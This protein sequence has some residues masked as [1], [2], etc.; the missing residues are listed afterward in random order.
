MHLRPT[1]SNFCRWKEINLRQYSFDSG[2]W[3]K[4]ML[5]FNWKPHQTQ[6]RRKMYV[7][8]MYRTDFYNFIIINI[9]RYQKRNQIAFT[10]LTSTTSMVV[11]TF[12]PK[13][14]EE[15]RN[16]WNKKKTEE[17]KKEISSSHLRCCQTKLQRVLGALRIPPPPP[18]LTWGG[19]E[20]AAGGG[21]TT[22]LS[23][24]SNQFTF[25]SRTEATKKTCP[26]IPGSLRWKRRAGGVNDSDGAGSRSGSFIAAPFHTDAVIICRQ[27]DGGE[28]SRFVSYSDKNTLV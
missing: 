2:Q 7:T 16:S 10:D 8:R 24:L 27:F 25:V 1:R 9:I 22:S 28:K 19:A 15:A 12:K 21:Q 20:G 14:E 11:W 26:S 18:R 17:E 23:S 6:S 13:P 3:R 5:K 4:K